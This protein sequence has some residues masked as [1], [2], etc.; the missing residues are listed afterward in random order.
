MFE[1]LKAGLSVQQCFFAA[2]IGV[3]RPMSPYELILQHQPHPTA[4]PTFK[5]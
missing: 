3:P 2:V 1:S 5:I 4:K